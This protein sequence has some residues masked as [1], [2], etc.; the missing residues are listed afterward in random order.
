MSTT[1]WEQ[2]AEAFF[3]ALDRDAEDRAAFLEAACADDP[4]LHD[5]VEAMLAAHKHGTGFLLEHRFL[6]DASTATTRAEAPLGQRVGPY[7][8]KRLI[9]RGGMGAVYLAERADGAFKQQVALKLVRYDAGGEDALLRFLNERQ[10]LAQL[11][12]PGIARLLDGG[13]TEDGQPYFAMEHVAGHPVDV[14]CDQ[15]R[16]SVKERLRLF[17]QVCTAVQF[18]HQNL[19]VHRD[20]KPSNVLVTPEGEVKL[21]DFGV[22]KLLEGAGEAPGL[23]RTGRHV[24][25]PEYASPEQV[26]GE[27]VTTASDAYQ[28]GVLLYELLAGRRPYRFEKRTPAEIERVVCEE[29]PQKPSAAISRTEEAEAQRIARRRAV[30]AERLRRQL[31][32]DLDTICL[33]ALQ[34][35]PGRRYGTAEAFGDDVKRHL[36]GLPVKA[37]PDTLSYRARKFVRRHR[38]GVI[39]AAAFVLLLVGFSAVTAWQARTVARERDAA[40]AERDR[41]EQVSAFLAGIFESADPAAAR[42]DTLTALELL[43]RGATQIENELAGQPAVQADMLDVMSRAYLGLG[44]YDRAE[45]LA[46]RALALRPEGDSSANTR[47]LTRLAEALEAQSRFA[48]ADSLFRL[49]VARHRAQ[50]D[51]AALIEAL[52]R[53]GQLLLTGLSSPDTVKAVYEEALA[54]RRQHYGPDDPGRGRVLRYYAGAYHVGG[55]YDTAERLFREAL[56][57]QR[58]FPGDPATTAETLY[59]LGAI[60]SYR[61]QHQEADS[62]LREAVALRE[63]LYGRGHPAT[64]EVLISLATNLTSQGRYDEAEGLLREAL[65]TYEQHTGRMSKG[66]RNALRTLRMTLSDAGRHEEAVAA[67]QEVVDLTEML[68]GADSRSYAT[69]LSHYAQVLS[70]ARRP[71]EALAV[72]QRALPLVAATLGDDVPFYAV[73]L[74]ESARATD[75]LGRTAKAEALFAQAYTILK[76]KLGPGNYQRSRVAFALGQRHAARGDHAGALPFFADAAGVHVADSVPAATLAARAA[77]AQGASLLAVGR[78]EEAEVCLQKAYKALRRLFGDDDPRAQ[79][80][81]RDLEAARAVV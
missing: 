74:A 60:L 11:Q 10:I 16:L 79:Q 30:Q 55:D 3:G 72:Y 27:A 37:Q 57:Q 66:Y 31:A 80:A 62:L 18:A 23:T 51:V 2:I 63:G 36:A 73:M 41:A 13:V 7:R 76:E 47:S 20:L 26:R 65:A 32:G 21:L 56:S 53:R 17:G 77:H 24:M 1:R 46:R 54:L 81:R 34:K 14:Y 25:T 58:R 28:L 40:Q 48:A 59:Q 43:G 61:R 8:L 70:N 22:A 12:H 67:A 9:G 6:A 68:Y 15:R 19:V 5:E 44:T 64:A 33:K 45:A 29:E 78:S 39:T 50:G 38:V 35:E 75:A 69:N 71:G 4:A 52:E 42:G 49:A